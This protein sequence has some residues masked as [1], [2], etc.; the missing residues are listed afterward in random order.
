MPFLQSLLSTSFKRRARH[1]IESWLLALLM[2]IL[3]V[4]LHELEK[5]CESIHCPEWMTAGLEVI[6]IIVFACDALV[7]VAVS[8]RFAYN[9]VFA[10]EE[11]P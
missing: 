3:A 10:P 8:V 7:V 1:L 9:T 5:L 6:S 2:L 11:H 4:G